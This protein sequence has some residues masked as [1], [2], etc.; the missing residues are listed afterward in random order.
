M[1]PISELVIFWTVVCRLSSLR[2]LPALAVFGTP[3]L[4]TRPGRLCW[5]DCRRGT[6]MLGT[7]MT[8]ASVHGWFGFGSR[9]G[10][11][12]VFTI[13]PGSIRYPLGCRRLL[14]MTVRLI[15]GLMNMVVVRTIRRVCVVTFMRIKRLL[16]KIPITIA[17]LIRFAWRRFTVRLSLMRTMRRI[18]LSV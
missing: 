17:T 8:C 12:L 16:V 9:R 13:G 15:M 3:L 5:R 14:L 11:T 4:V 18:L 6:P 2:R 7:L 1:C 10:F